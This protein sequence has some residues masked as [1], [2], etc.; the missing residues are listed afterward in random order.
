MKHPL[1]LYTGCGQPLSAAL[2][3]FSHTLPSS[4]AVALLYTPAQCLFARLQA[5]DVLTD[6]MA[7]PVA[8]DAV[9]EA[10][11]FHADAELRWLND[12][13]P[14]H[15]HRTVILSVQEQ[16]LG[17]TASPVQQPI[18]STLPQTY[19]LWGEGVGTVHG[20]A[21][22]WSRLA[23]ARIGK[24]DVPLP[25]VHRNQ[26]VVLHAL[27]YLAEFDDGNVAVLE[28]RLIKLEVSR[29]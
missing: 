16:D 20:L 6:S 24:L 9:Y 13:G 18:V 21:P 7:H 17:L 25:H 1:F 10:R 14:T 28:E 29:G 27:E 2:D 19:L 15:H 26:Y 11:V 22:G 5:A 8:L 23:T 12:P 3:A 4:G